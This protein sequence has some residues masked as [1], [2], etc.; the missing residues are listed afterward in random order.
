[1]SKVVVF[2]KQSPSLKEAQEIVGGYVELVNLNGGDAMLVNEEG[3]LQELPYNDKASFL[4]D[5]FVVGDVCVVK[6]EIR[7]EDW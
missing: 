2:D 1:M 6:K 3:L 4:A 7:G 5:R